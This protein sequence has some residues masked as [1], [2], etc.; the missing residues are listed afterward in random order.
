MIWHGGNFVCDKRGSLDGLLAACVMWAIEYPETI[1][2]AETHG[3]S[4]HTAVDIWR[5]K[6][7]QIVGRRTEEPGVVEIGGLL[8]GVEVVVEVSE[9]LLN[10]AKRTQLRD[11]GRPQKRRPWGASGEQYGARFALRVLERA[12][13]RL[14]AAREARAKSVGLFENR[15]TAWVAHDG[16]RATAAL[17]RGGSKWNAP[18]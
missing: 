7:H 12:A 18:S 3:S 2:Y 13:A 4:A 15:Y 16:W 9:T 8:G 17:P 6:M 11:A 1:I 5:N 14:T 10:N